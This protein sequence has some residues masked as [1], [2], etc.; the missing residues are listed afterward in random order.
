MTSNKNL[1]C[2]IGIA[3]ALLGVILNFGWNN[4]SFVLSIYD[5]VNE[6]TSFNPNSNV[7]LNG[8]FAPVAEEVN[9][10]QLQVVDGKIPREI[11]VF[12]TSFTVNRKFADS[13]SIIMIYFALGI[14]FTSRAKSNPSPYRQE[15]LSLV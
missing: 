5:N 14:I 13:V 2:Y 8:N 7:Y 15:R 4:I 12:L 9:N 6:L 1:C 3:V 11:E 10:I